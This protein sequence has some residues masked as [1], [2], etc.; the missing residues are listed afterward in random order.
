[1]NRNPRAKI[2]GMM[3]EESF[4]RKKP[5]LPHFKV[6][7]C[8]AYVHVPDDLRSKLD[9]RAENVCLLDTH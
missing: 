6:F 2:H 3:L 7:G 9:P 8:L 4:T 5:N 1:M